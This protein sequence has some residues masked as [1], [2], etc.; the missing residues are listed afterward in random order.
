MSEYVERY[1][2]FGHESTWGSLPS[3]WS[4]ASYPLSFE[5]TTTEN[6]VEEDIIGA[7]RQAKSNVWVNREVTGSY[8]GNFL[9][10]RL[11]Y[12]A[13][14]YASSNANSP[15]TVNVS[16]TLSV[17]SFSVEKGLRGASTIYATYKGCKVDRYELEIENLQDIVQTVDFVARDTDIPSYGNWNT[18]AVGSSWVTDPFAYHESCFIFESS[19]LRLRRVRLEI[20]NN[21][22]ARY[23]GLC[24]SQDP[25]PY[26]IREG[27]QEISGEFVLDEDIEDLVDNYVLAREKGTI[28]IKI[29]NSNRGTITITLN[30]VV[31]GEFRDSTRGAEPYEVTFPFKAKPSGPSDYDAITVQYVNTIAGTIHDMLW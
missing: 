23:A 31:L 6:L 15:Y 21:L 11:M 19:T 14:G 18:I 5:A 10:P 3:S 9:S 29:G 26:E 25:L 12:Y 1:V 2:R 30:N 20:N 27:A 13:L 8:S 7:S 28:V 24:T 22:S 16:G 4:I 17:P